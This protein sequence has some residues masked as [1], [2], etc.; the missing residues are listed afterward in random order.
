MNFRPGNVVELL[1]NGDRFFPALERAIGEAKQEIHLETYIFE[2]D[3]TGLRIADALMYAARRGVAVHVLV[4]GFGSRLFPE[5]LTNQML[6]AGVWLLVFRPEFAPWRLRRH[7]LRRLHRKIAVI[8]GRVGFCGGINIIDDRNTPKQVPPR[9]DYTVRVEGPIVSDMHTAARQLWT[10][11]TW[12]HFKQAWRAHSHV[13]PVARA[14]GTQTAAFLVRDNF[15]HRRDIED[16]YLDAIDGS[17]EEIVIA[18]A[19]FLPGKRFRRALCEAAQRG[20]RVILLLQG[21]VE[22]LLLHFASHALYRQLLEAGVVIYEYRRSF[23]HAKVS[24]VD[25]H[26]ATVGSSNLDPFSVLLAREANVVVE[27]RGFSGQ[28]RESLGSAIA[29]GAALVAREA[30]RPPL[31]MRIANW[32]AYGLVRLVMGL[33]GYPRRME[34]A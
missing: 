27:D 33:S 16:A 6:E 12:T 3:A 2:A 8:D 28:L 24:V 7:R 4:D 10:R 25:G 19:Y 29:T 30:W 14:V 1:E 15:R 17:R 22:Y 34:N 13:R 32:L 26:W 5:A 20:V 18:C 21:K 31:P 11:V 9:Y 23:L